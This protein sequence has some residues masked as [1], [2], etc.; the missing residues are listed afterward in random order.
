MKNIEVEGKTIY[1]SNVAK[2][3]PNINIVSNVK[4]F[5]LERNH[6][7]VDNV[8]KLLPHVEIRKMKGFTLERNPMHVSPVGKLSA[9]IC[10]MKCRKKF[11]LGRNHNFEV[12]FVLVFSCTCFIFCVINDAS[13]IDAVFHIKIFIYRGLAHVFLT[14]MCSFHIT[15]TVMNAM[16]FM[17]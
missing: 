2:F 16:F 12:A 11:T 10:I 7:Y 14:L 13:E 5:T 15:C 9:Q 17:L 1:V 6:I 3:L 4:D 8:G